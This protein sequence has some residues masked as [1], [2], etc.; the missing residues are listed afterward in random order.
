MFYADVCFWLLP[1]FSILFVCMR[2]S[3]IGLLSMCSIVFLLLIAIIAVHYGCVLLD[4]VSIDIFDVRCWCVV[5]IVTVVFNIVS[6]HSCLSYWFV[7]D[8][9]NCV[10]CCWLLSLRL[11]RFHIDLYS[12]MSLFFVDDLH[13]WFYQLFSLP[14]ATAL[15]SREIGPAECATRLNKEKL[16]EKA[17]DHV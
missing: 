8:V 16:W 10:F 3:L 14:K 1:L 5:L 11:C 2:L 4:L 15:S 7:I 9:F 12:W 17:N 6:L 13:D